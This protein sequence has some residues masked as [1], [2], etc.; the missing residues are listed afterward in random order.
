MKLLATVIAVA[1]LLL[2][3]STALAIYTDYRE[4]RR[5][6]YATVRHMARLVADE[7]RHTIEQADGV[8]LYLVEVIEDAG[9]PGYA[10]TA[11]GRKELLALG[12]LMP[13]ESTLRLVDAQGNLLARTPEIGQAAPNIADR[14]YFADIRDSPGLVIE[15]A[16]P[17]RID[18]KIRFLFGRPFHLPEGGFG[19]IAIANIDSRTLTDFYDLLSFDKNPVVT[20]RTVE[21]DIVARRPDMA[22]FLG[23]KASSTPLYGHGF[24]E[25]PAGEFIGISPFDHVERIVAYRSIPEYGLRLLVAI[26]RQAAFAGWRRRALRASAVAGGAALLLVAMGYWGWRSMKVQRTLAKRV[27][28]EA[29]RR[30]VLQRS[31]RQAQLDPLTRLAGR[32]FLAEHGEA[33]A[34]DSAERGMSL[35]VLFVDLDDFKC[36]NDTYGHQRGDEI[37]VEVARI[38]RSCLRERDVALRIGGDEFLILAEMPPSEAEQ[39][40]RQ[41]AHRVAS[42]LDEAELGV[43]CSI[44]IATRA[45]ARSS[46]GKAI[47]EADQAMYE[48]KRRKDMPA[49]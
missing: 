16:A 17:S 26:D 1:S 8:L 21:G 43:R 34:R 23:T 35:S 48:A 5:S 15:P 40:T 7:T 22:G 46:L 20:V 28:A 10:A 45:E 41:M 14:A 3:M 29:M 4:V 25:Q 11:R 32:S 49:P 6:E 38:L 13:P 30:R 47:I 36:V 37:L 44:G 19:G 24:P 39:T 2:A 33:L 18:G 27:A 31:L 9:D 42:R 12:R